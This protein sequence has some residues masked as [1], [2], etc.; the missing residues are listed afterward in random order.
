MIWK[1]YMTV[2]LFGSSWQTQIFSRFF[3]ESS[4]QSW[5]IL[6]AAITPFSAVIKFLYCNSGLVLTWIISSIIFVVI[7]K[8]VAFCLWILSFWLSFFYSLHFCGSIFVTLHED[9]PYFCT[10]ELVSWKWPCVGVWKQHV[11]LLWECEFSSFRALNT[12]ILPFSWDLKI[13]V[14]NIR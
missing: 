3:R 14:H 8:S 11:D 4:C 13:N 12:L 6:P 7:N 2:W 5:P 10:L 9:I 1:P